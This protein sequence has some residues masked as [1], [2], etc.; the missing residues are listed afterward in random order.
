MSQ[1]GASGRRRGKAIAAMLLALCVAAPELGGVAAAATSFTGRD[2]SQPTEVALVARRREASHRERSRI[3]AFLRKHPNVLTRRIKKHP[4]YVARRMRRGAKAKPGA[5]AVRKANQ[6]KRRARRG[7]R[8]HARRA[9]ARRHVKKNK[10]NR[11]RTAAAVAAAR[12]KKGNKG[13]KSAARGKNAKNSG[14][15]LGWKDWL[16]IG[17]L[18]LAPF[19]AVALLLY[20]TDLRRRPRAPSR[21]KRRRSLV[22]TPTS[23]G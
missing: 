10:K 5:R 20:I 8:K 18:I 6:K 17:L 16:A 13:N 15:P 7:G 3:R 1:N 2:T 23:K 21:S 19:A 22:I 9:N 14:D 4:N 12:K 11:R